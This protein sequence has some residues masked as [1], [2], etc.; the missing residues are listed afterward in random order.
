MINIF[1]Y[2][3]K[4]LAKEIA[5][6]AKSIDSD[7][8]VTY[9]Q[10]SNE[11]K[12]GSGDDDNKYTLFLGNIFNKFSVLSKADRL[13]SIEAYLEEVLRPA[14][15]SDDQFLN[16]LALRVR[17]QYEIGFRD[18]QF[19]LSGHDV[20]PSLRFNS[21]SMVIEVVSDGEESLSIPSAET[22]AKHGAS[23]DEAIEIACAKLRRYTEK[24]KW[25]KIDPSIWVSSYRD[26]YDIARLIATPPYE[27][28]P[29]DND[30]VMYAPSH[31][32]CLI[33][34]VKTPEVLSRMIQIGDEQ[35]ANHRSFSQS[36]WGF[37]NEFKELNA[38]DYS[39]GVKEIVELQSLKEE[40]NQYQETKA[41]FEKAVTEDIFI[42]NF[43]AIQ[44]DN[45]PISYCVY[46][47]DLPSYLPK[48][49]YVAIVDP[50]LPEDQTFIGWLDWKDFYDLISTDNLREVSNTIPQW[51]TLLPEL[52]SDLKDRV[53]KATRPDI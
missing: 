3:E 31:S 26:D 17:T 41:Y 14:E 30:L 36:L 1:K 50:S 34:N 37:D 29:F 8:V 40:I 49:E 44:N 45:G 32:V 20:Q 19:K 7:L 48:A 22:I 4:K 39:T 24:Q 52:G 28:L 38:S 27:A 11:V 18:K 43:K 2:T 9:L 46:T 47:L 51:Y 5:S 23:N 6:I 15:L 10:N 53:K 42:A 33:T 25:E 16:T 12:L 13:K 35:S 21:G